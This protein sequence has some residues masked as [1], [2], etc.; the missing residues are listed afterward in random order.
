MNYTTATLKKTI[1]LFV[2]S[3]I[4]ISL[5][6][7]I[8][9]PLLFDRDIFRYD[10][11]GYYV[12]NDLGRGRNIGYRL[13]LFLLEIKTLNALL[14]MSLAFIANMAIDIAWIYLFSKYLSLRSLV[15]FVLMLGFQPYAAV[16]T[17]KFSTILFAKIGIFFFCNEL[18]KGGFYNIKQKTLSFSEIFFWTVLTLIRNANLFIAAPYM[19]VK[20]RN[21]PIMAILV[22]I[23][24]TSGIIYV[25]WWDGLVVGVNPKSWPWN[26]TY[27]KDL[28]GVEN[29]FIALLA[30]FI[31]KIILLFGAREKLHNLG[32]EPFLVWGIPALELCVYFLIGCIQFFGFCYAMQFIF[33]K[34]GII[35]LIILIPIGFA[36]LTVSHQRYLLPYIPI[37]LFGLS[38]AFNK[39]K[40]FK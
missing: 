19:F 29:N 34:H 8:I 36:L 21:K 28:L 32:I 13:L 22:C 11:F 30:T 27:V 5:I 39:L 2:I 26:I 37:C 18:F 6:F 33:Q 40:Q 15:L 9:M 4:I 1:L 35:S 16:Y 10:D 20:L 24:F 14:P 12:S 23:V 31:S 7:F 25:S 38:L 17:V 3:K